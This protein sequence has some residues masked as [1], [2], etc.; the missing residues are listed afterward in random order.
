M[1]TCLRYR[2]DLLVKLLNVLFSSLLLS[3]S[4]YLA[5]DYPSTYSCSSQQRYIEQLATN[6]ALNYNEW[7]VQQIIN[8]LQSVYLNYRDKHTIMLLLAHN[9]C[10]PANHELTRYVKNYTEYYAL[11][12]HER[13]E[14]V[15][16]LATNPCLSSKKV[17]M[18]IVFN[19]LNEPW[20]SERVKQKILAL[21]SMN[22]SIDIRRIKTTESFD[23]INYARQQLEAELL[24]NGIVL[25][26]LGVINLINWLNNE[27]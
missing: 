4:A 17:L 11:S 7:L 13:R 9:P 6:P 5:A 1:S 16:A 10:T 25:T 22:P 12:C 23:E 2:R 15:Y 19:Y 21:L 27:E 8:H 14:M 26:T 24:A 18:D 20:Q 3:S